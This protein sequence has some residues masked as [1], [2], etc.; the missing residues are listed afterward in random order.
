MFKELDWHDCS[1]YYIVIC[2][3][4]NELSYRIL[5]II[6]SI[7]ERRNGGWKYGSGNWESE[8]YDGMIQSFTITKKFM[9]L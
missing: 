9:Q 1:N 6:T 2:V 3:P 5:I 4:A 7:L 8:R